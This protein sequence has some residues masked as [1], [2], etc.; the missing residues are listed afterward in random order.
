MV[1]G[2]CLCYAA[3]NSQI[4]DSEYNIIHKWANDYDLDTCKTYTRNICLNEPDSVICGDVRK[5]DIE[6]LGDIDAL[7]FGFPCN[8][9][10]AVREYLLRNNVEIY[11]DAQSLIDCFFWRTDKSKIKNGNC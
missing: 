4:E 2:T 9:F 5:L 8:D 1:R 10:S 3:I 11:G 6:P 7:A